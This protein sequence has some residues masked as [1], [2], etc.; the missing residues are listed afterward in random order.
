MSE[1][2]VDTWTVLLWWILWKKCN[3]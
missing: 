1:S 2:A 3:Y